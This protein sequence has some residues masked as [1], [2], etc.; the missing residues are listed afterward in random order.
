M[1]TNGGSSWIS[2][3]N[4]YDLHADFHVILFAA[5]GSKMYVGNDGGVWSTSNLG[6]P[7]VTWNNLNNT[8][9]VTQFYPGLSISAESANLSLGGTQDNGTQMYTGSLTWRV[10]TCGDGMWTAIDPSNSSIMYSR[11]A[12]PSIMKSAD[13]GSTWMD[14]SSGITDSHWFLSPLVMDLAHSNSLYY[15]T[16]SR[17]WQTTDGGSNWTAISP[18]IGSFITIAVSPTNSSTL[19]AATFQSLW[20]TTNG[21]TNWTQVTSGI[22][23]RYPAM[24][25][26]DP[27]AT[28][29]FYVTFSGFSGFGGDTKGHV[30]KCT[31]ASKACSDISSNLPNIPVNDIV[32]DPDLPSTYYVATDGGVFQT[33]NGGSTWTT[34]S[35]GLPNVVVLSLKLHRSSRTLRAA[36]HGRSVWDIVVPDLPDLTETSVSNP[37]AT[38]LDGGSFSVTDTVR[39]IGSG[40]AA[41]STTRYYL[42]TTPSK[43][44]A[45]RLTG[46]RAVPSLASGATSSGTVTVTVSAGTAAGT[47]FLLACADD[48]HVVR[49]TKESN[50]CKASATQVTVSGPDLVETNVSNPPPTV[51]RGGT[52]SVTDTVLNQGTAAA[53]VSVTRYYL[54]L[55]KAQNAGD[56]LLTGTRS[57]PALAASAS[58]SGTATVTV[59]A[60]TNTGVYYL[61]ACADDT[62]IVTESNEKNNC[63]ASGGTVTVVISGEEPLVS[64]K[65]SRETGRPRVN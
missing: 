49:E 26:G 43:G 53:G 31:T 1:S 5:G 25:Q 20:F 30:F 57:V 28:G 56:K 41:A 16:N 6:T 52:F 59:P 27:T 12:F 9:A 29:T 54:S 34:F 19:Y 8:L 63:L 33:T 64:D 23:P 65:Q 22:P 21:G 7:T 32:I 60:N 62:K 3:N 51:T 50:N 44:G 58:S 35:N 18:N 36:T 2:V 48:T 15:G 10:A 13:S 11:C 38:V 40:A 45:H 37:P 55:D 47:Y 4:N 24:V 14:I 39:N 46:S 17:V 42:S 61:L